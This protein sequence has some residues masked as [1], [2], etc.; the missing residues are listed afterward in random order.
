MRTT[1]S[2]SAGSRLSSMVS[3][4][5]WKPGSDLESSKPLKVV[6][7]ASVQVFGTRGAFDSGSFAPLQESR[8]VMPGSNCSVYFQHCRIIR[9]GV[10][11]REIFA[12]LHFAQ[13]RGG[14]R[15][16]GRHHHAGITA[17]LA[18]HRSGGGAAD[19]IIDHQQHGFGLGTADQRHAL[20]SEHTHQPDETSHT[21]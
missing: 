15:E 17:A 20:I 13:A 2:P 6:M 7:V 3:T 21:A 11:A 5:A 12:R 18:A 8:L 9:R 16:F 1:T 14:A 19:A 10:F 4:A